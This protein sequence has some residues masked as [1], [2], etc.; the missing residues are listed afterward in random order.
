MASQK[1]ERDASEAFNGEEVSK[2]QAKHFTASSRRN[3][4]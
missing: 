2:I 1:D 3:G 4:I